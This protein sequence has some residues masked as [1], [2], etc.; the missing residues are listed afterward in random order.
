VARSRPTSDFLEHSAGGGFGGAVAAA[1]PNGSGER[2]FGLSPTMH[3]RRAYER[4]SM[5]AEPLELPPLMR[6]R[7]REMPS[8]PTA[9]DRFA[10]LLDR[11]HRRLRRFVAGMLLDRDQVDDVLQEAY[12]RAFRRLPAR[13]AND[14]HEAAWIYR[15]VYRCAVDE[16]RRRKRR[17]VELPIDDRSAG[18]EADE[19]ARL[20]VGAAFESLSVE[21]RAALLLVDVAGFGYDE[22]AAALRI[23]RG[24]LAWRLSV[25][26]GRF[27]NVLVEEELR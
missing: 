17:R 3:V 19:V 16:L 14:A 18:S 11:H 1:Q 26:R 6:H 21:D 7:A 23:P 8:A 2:F 22:A 27:R 12:L 24:T 10:G 15:V 13:F 5:S 9:E 20:A 25:A 4:M